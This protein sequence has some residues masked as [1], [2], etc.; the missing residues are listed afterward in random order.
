[1]R[2]ISSQYN[3]ILFLTDLTAKSQAALA[4]ARNLAKFYN[5]YLGVLH[6]L[7]PPKPH[8][9]QPGFEQ[10][11]GGN[12]VVV[13]KRLEA[14]AKALRADGISVQVRLCR[15]KAVSRSILKNIHAM[16]PDLIIQGSGAIDDLRR[17]FLGSIAEE[18]LRST[19][20][21]VLTVPASLKR[22]SQSL[23]FD[24]ILFATDFG[25]AARS[26][27]FQAV[28]LAQ[29]FGARVILCHVHA[30]DS[31]AV[32]TSGEFCKFFETE[33]HRLLSPSDID[34]CDPKCVVTS[35]KPFEAIL[36]LAESERCDLIVLGAHALG[37]LGSRG[38]PGTAFR[39]I[40]GAHCPVLTVSSSKHDE[41]DLKAEQIEF[42][43]A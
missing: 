31:T 32:W 1:M 11:G 18:V 26:T 24:R 35:G 15:S 7:P 3:K 12:T 4:Y 42:I 43:E 27:A 19:A 5:A 23:R 36:K 14:L 20:K 25:S 29:D 6:V 10:T 30:S 17:A 38:K 28:S 16:C 40:S 13:R 34:L 41:E 9:A 33:L 21:P 2:A 37:P 8:S 22:T 39:V